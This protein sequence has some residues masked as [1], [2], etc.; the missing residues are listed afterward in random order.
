MDLANPVLVGRRGGLRGADQAAVPPGPVRGLGPAAAAR[1]DD[2]PEPSVQEHVVAQHLAGSLVRVVVEGLAGV[3][4]LT[5]AVAPRRGPEQAAPDPF[6]R[7]RL[8]LG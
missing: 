5:P 1:P 8:A 4:D 3:G 2:P 6:P 7:P